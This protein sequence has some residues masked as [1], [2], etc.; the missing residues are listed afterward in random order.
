MSGS[1]NVAVLVGSLRTGSYSRKIAAALIARAPQALNCN[2]VEIGEL[3]L[4]NEDLEQASPPASWVDFRAALR[5]ADGVLFVTPEYNRS[6]P[7]CLKNALDVGSRPE[8]Q[9]VFDGVPAAVVSVT[10]YKLGAFGAN[11]ALR[12]TFVF[13]NMPVLQQPELYLGQAA[14]LLDEDGK[15]KDEKAG[16]LLEQFMSS[17]ERWMRSVRSGNH[18]HDFDAFMRE[19]QNIARDYVNG[20][21][22]SLQTILTQVEPATFFSPGGDVQQGARAISLRYMGDAKSFL[23]GS[24]TKLEVLH[25]GAS[26]ELA[27]WT[28]VQRAEVRTTSGD[29]KATMAL[30]VTEVFRFESGGFKLVHRHADPLQ[31]PQNEPEK[32]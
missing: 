11:H 27:Y 19:R 1:L 7:G 21:P 12:Q 31:S 16:H 25:C 8:K 14:E 2:I 3:P 6:I 32:S 15:V 24:S 9:S 13:L 18:V 30:R 26:G 17:F 22:T 28:G 5:R 4:Y 10:P 29:E 23:T 20:D